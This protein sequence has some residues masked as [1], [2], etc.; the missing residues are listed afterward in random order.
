MLRGHDL[1]AR[2]ALDL[3][4]LG[5]VENQEMSASPF[6]TITARVVASGTLFM[7]SVLTFGT[8]RQ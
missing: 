8:R 6:F 2:V 4:G 7:I 1:Q 5:S 3:L